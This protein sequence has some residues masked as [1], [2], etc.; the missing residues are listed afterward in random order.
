MWII[1]SLLSALF[2]ALM[3]IFIK[4]GLKGI[5]P[6]L[7][8][9]IRSIIV[10]L[11]LLVFIVINNSIKEI[12]AIDKN[13]WIWLFLTAVVTFATWVFYYLALSKNDAYKVASLEKISIIIV[14]ILSFFV[15]NEKITILGIL[16][17][18]LIL[19][20]SIMTSL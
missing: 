13:K 16:G 7:S 1:F 3:T 15:L 14:F 6:I 19:V 17:M 12:K 2:G 5:N 9:T 4:L 10:C 18:I 20:G 8:L 11:F